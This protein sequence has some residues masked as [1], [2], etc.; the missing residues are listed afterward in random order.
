[1]VNKRKS[2]LQDALIQQK[3]DPYLPSWYQESLEPMQDRI[4]LNNQNNSF[5][6]AEK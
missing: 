3:A 2:P 5:R 4:R 1:M 6:Y